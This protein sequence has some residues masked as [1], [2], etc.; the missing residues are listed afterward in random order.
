[1]RQHFP[2]KQS[3]KKF[4][5]AKNKGTH[6]LTSIHKGMTNKPKP[7]LFLW[8]K[9]VSKTLLTMKI[10]VLLFIISILPASAA[11]VFSQN[12]IISI[13][14]QNVTV[15]EALHELERHG[16]ISFIYNENLPG[17]HKIVDLTFQDKPIKDVLRAT[18]A[19]ADIK[20]AE[21]REDFIVLLSAS[22]QLQAPAYTVTGRVVDD[23]GVTLPG[24]TIVVKG[25]PAI[26]T[27]TDIDGRF[28]INVPDADATLVFSFIGMATQEVALEGR[29]VLNVVLGRAITALDEV[30]VVG[31]GTIRKV[32]I[33]GSVS[34]VSGDDMIIAPQA[35][36][37]MGLQGRVA[38]LQM[39]STSAEP[40]GGISV[41][42][43][44]TNS[45][46]G[47]NEP[48]YVIDGFPMQNDNLG[49]TGGWEGQRPT[50][51]LA[52]LNP[53]D[54]ESVQVLKDASAT[55]IYGARG[56]NGVIL[57]TTKRGRSGDARVDFDYSQSFSNVGGGPFPL[58][59][60]Y[61]YA[62]LENEFYDN[63]NSTNHRFTTAPNR[64]G[65]Q[66]VSPEELRTTYGDGTDWFDHV[67]QTGMTSNYN[68]AIHG[69][70]RVLY[71][72]SGN[73]YTERG[74]VIASDFNRA[75]FRVNLASQV[76][77]RLK[78]DVSL[79]QSRTQGS[80]MLQTGRVLAGGPNRLGI[81]TE[82]F[83]AS[84]ITTPE[85]AFEHNNL[86]Q[87]VTG[88]GGVSHFIYN[89]VRQANEVTNSNAS[90]F[91]IGSANLD[92]N[93]LNDLKIT[94]RAGGNILDEER[95]LFY[96]MSV[97]LGLQSNGMGQHAVFKKNDYLFENF[98]TYNKT[99]AEKH[100]VN[101]VGGYSVQSEERKSI[102]MS[103]SNYAVDLLGIYGWSN[104]NNPMSPS[105]GIS[106]INT[107]SVYG[108]LFYNFNDR[109]LV[110][111]TGRR[112]GS[113]VF[114]EERKYSFFP[115]VAVAWNVSNEEFLSDM[116]ALSDLKVR[117]SYGLVGN[118]AISPYQSLARAGSASYP[119]GTATGIGYMP[120]G[121]PN[122][123][124]LWETTRQFNA[125]VDVG[126]L[127]RYNVSIDYYKKNTVD[128]LQAKPVPTT[129]GYT[130]FTTN[131]GEISNTG[132]ELQLGARVLQGPLRWNTDISWSLNRSVIEDLGLAVDGT[133]IEFAQVPGTQIQ[134]IPS[135]M[136]V[137]GH[138][139]GTFW[140]WTLDGLLQ[141]S[142][143]DA[144]YPLRG[145]QRLGGMKYVDVNDDGVIN[146]LDQ[147]VIGTAQPDFI[148]GWNNS[149]S[150]KRFTMNLFIN[151]V[152]GGQI[153][154]L[155]RI[156][157][158]SG[159]FGNTGGRASQEY[160]DDYWRP[161]NTDAK[162]P[163][164][165]GG[166]NAAS[167]FLLEDATYVRV[168]TIS[169][170]YQIPTARVIFIR[171]SEVYLMI[172]NLFTFTNYS[173]FDPEVSFSGQASYAANLDQG[174]YPRPRSVT[175]GVRM[176]L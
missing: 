82:A 155:S 141:Q 33:T 68:L 48:L 89:P 115:S 39:T 102:G 150:Y 103:G 3:K 80:R 158:H 52:S 29:T 105:T 166:V 94:M 122:A 37:E 81:I 157:T 126:F 175:F 110:T 19:M 104:L 4:P 43:R 131:F 172:D 6:F 151:G 38:G 169:L 18:L 171:S 67:L 174:A 86:L 28:A 130:S 34:T 85:Q 49:R 51:L 5:S 1:M 167:T 55:A 111:F 27:V 44:G 164:P 93:I 60:V 57:I 58:V 137:K 71:H 74:V 165:G 108:R 170:A 100:T 76:N 142:D 119:F 75:Q 7:I 132:V 129:T 16:G 11:S 109:Y 163:A 161:D 84:P 127:E 124:L 10:L 35:N 66:N 90:N 128:L 95:I 143:F 92:Y 101:L 41:N 97:P 146:D 133:P 26:G 87:H 22:D 159:L 173:G 73:Y 145:A 64:W 54:I 83:R 139:V 160:A 46:L 70:D 9:R 148:F 20:Y 147:G 125:G 168:K 162:H 56:A 59:N 61:D 176:G 79:S 25:S 50:N 107:A 69:G 144:G 17:L 112:D 91:F 65:L 116:T 72:I 23:A 113:S 98:L 96:P 88:S 134:N 30:V 121:A 31:Y 114:A 62:R 123:N 99:F 120:T 136:F 118:Q 156:Y 45:L 63:T 47:N 153:M 135:H 2:A 140:G 78:V 106:Q 40:G 154:N 138:P 117:A 42:V 8:H 53:N 149:L 12:A 14:M 24:V 152:V 32:D 21:I 77:D 15:R 13:D 36:F